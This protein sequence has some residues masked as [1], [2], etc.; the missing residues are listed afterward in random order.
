MPKTLRIAF[1]KTGKL[2]YISH[3]DLCRT[4][5]RIMLRSEVPIWYSEG[6]NPHPKMVF[7]LPLS[8]GTESVCELMDIKIP[9]D[10]EPSAVAE[11]LIPASF[12]GL[13]FKEAYIPDK[14]F[15]LVDRAS[16]VITIREGKSVEE[17]KKILSGPIVVMK[18]TKSGEKLTDISEFIK[19]FE[20]SEKDGNI[21]L[22]IIL[23]ASSENYLNPEYIASSV[24][25]EDYS[26]LRT[27]MYAGNVKFK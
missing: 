24:G 23:S 27:A 1:E 5:T 17:I 18:R 26:I 8:V 15:S 16:Y 20:C 22:D 6:F 21:I 3:L 11:K 2:K 25:A 12:G 19:S 4:M 10:V 7:A 14:K 13:V 9:D